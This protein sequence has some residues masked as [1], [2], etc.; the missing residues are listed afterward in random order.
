MLA[1]E[2]SRPRTRRT[3]VQISARH[4]SSDDP[5]LMVSRLVPW[6]DGP[7]S[8]RAF[9]S[10]VTNAPPRPE[11]ETTVPLTPC[12]PRR[13]LESRRGRCSRSGAPSPCGPP[14]PAPP[15]PKS[16][17]RT[18]RARTAATSPPSAR[19]EPKTPPRALRPRAHRRRPP[20]LPRP[21]RRPLRRFAARNR[22][23]L[24]GDARVHAVRPAVPSAAVMDPSPPAAPSTTAPA[25]P[26]SSPPTPPSP[27][28]AWR[29]PA[30][31][32]LV[33]TWLVTNAAM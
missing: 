16:R 18:R 7:P 15:P 6:I 27:P 13:H 19:A 33:V 25:A 9:A 4:D 32:S 30:P 29:V 1:C 5:R 10:S 22:G 8:P 21:P 31:P 23:A 2:S 12:V 20:L 24:H 28:V 11:N 14:S 3:L 17:T 26:P